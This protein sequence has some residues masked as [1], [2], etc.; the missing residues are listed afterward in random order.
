MSLDP[1]KLSILTADLHRNGVS[2]LPFYAA[3]VDDANEGD[4]KLV[5]MFEDEG[6]TA[7][8][9]LNKLIEEDVQFG[10]NSY[11]GDVY[12]SALRQELWGDSEDEVT[13]E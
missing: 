5:V 2:G 13:D 9:S 1:N 11:R 6:Y 3:L 8:L 4:V 10:S 7:V 12:E